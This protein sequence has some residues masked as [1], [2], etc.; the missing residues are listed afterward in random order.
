MFGL[1]LKGPHTV[2]PF[3]QVSE[4]AETCDRVYGSSSAAAMDLFRLNMI[5]AI[6]SVSLTRVG[7]HESPILGY[8]AAAM[9]H[10]KGA[11][12]L[13]GV[14]AIQNILLVLIFRIYYHTSGTY[15]SNPSLV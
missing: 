15:E 11:L 13:N 10:I 7:L 6:G 12:R 5:F 2:H 3:L 4:V 1:S 8:Y 14:E 9:V